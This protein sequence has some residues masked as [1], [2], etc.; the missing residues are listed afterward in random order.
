MAR[1]VIETY[2]DINVA[3]AA[4]PFTV[5]LPTGTV[6]GNLLLCIM[7]KDDDPAVVSNSGMV[8]AF[9]GGLI[10]GDYGSYA[11]WKIATAA[12]ITTGSVSFSG[13][14]S[15]EYVGRLYR[16][17]GVNATNPIFAVSS[18]NVSSSTSP[19]ALT[20]T[21]PLNVLVFAF[22][23]ADTADTPYSIVTG[24]WSSN[25]NATSS[26]GQCG[27]V[28]ATRDATTAGATGSVVFSTNAA[29]G[30]AAGQ[31]AINGNAAPTTA[32]VSPG[33]TNDVA[34]VNPDLVF[35]GTDA[36]GDELDY[37]VQIDTVNSFDSQVGS[38]TSAG[39]AFTA[40][41]GIAVNRL[42]HD[43]WVCSSSIVSGQVYKQTGGVGSFVSQG[44]S[45]DQYAGIAVNPQN[46]DVY[47]CTAGAGGT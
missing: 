14:S 31:I 41:E 16:I 36:D 27:I 24:G 17:S 35:A 13:D 44:L 38:W 9:A 28:I 23:G 5:T 32:L 2:R 18:P 6:A 22:F 45:A 1:P 11:F 37:Q 30:W 25:L 26:D 21:A 46:G 42:T 10:G 43:V 29:D 40:W 15:E 3:A 4:T 33:D 39:A 8:D 34:T 19:T 7:S 20:L 47:L 12:D